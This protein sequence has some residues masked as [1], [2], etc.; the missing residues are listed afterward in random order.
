MV[1][2]NF[3]PKNYE[4]G[5]NYTLIPEGEHRVRIETV[6]EQKSRRSGR[7][8]LK[9]TLAVSGHNGK[10]WYY[11][12]LM[13]EEP[14]KTD[15]SLGALF[16]CFGIEPDMNTYTWIGTVG[17]VRVEH[18]EYNGKPTAKIAYLIPRSKQG[19]SSSWSEGG[20]NY[21][22]SLREELGD[23]EDANLPF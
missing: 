22:A 13:P 20:T 21:G 3:N 1:Q 17:K 19:D 2:W 6:E 15:Q 7:D 10:L 5:K 11:I 12:V 8:M 23:E 9:I 16:D 18:G 4:P 14:E